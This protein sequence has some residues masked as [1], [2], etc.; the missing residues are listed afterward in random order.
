MTTAAAEVARLLSAIA[1]LAFVSLRIDI[2]GRSAASAKLR[3]PL[4]DDVRSGEIRLRPL[5][6]EH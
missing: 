3:D 4:R 6:H 1:T 5:V 2:G